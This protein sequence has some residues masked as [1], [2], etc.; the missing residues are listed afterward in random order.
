MI[1]HTVY[2]RTES[3]WRLSCGNNN[4][5]NTRSWSDSHIYLLHPSPSPGRE[6]GRCWS[7]SFSPVKTNKTTTPLQNKL[8]NS[9]NIIGKQHITAVRCWLR[10]TKKKKTSDRM[11]EWTI[12]S[13]KA[14]AGEE[15]RMVK[16]GNVGRKCVATG[17]IIMITTLQGTI[18]FLPH[19]LRV[20]PKCGTVL[21]WSFM[22]T[23]FRVPFHL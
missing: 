19:H 20:Y 3:S 4:G 1:C 6:I 2:N 12:R 14:D 11:N 15:D 7:S 18:F 22:R 8:T 13:R 16:W 23:V 5:P 17:I 9:N 21:G 10:R